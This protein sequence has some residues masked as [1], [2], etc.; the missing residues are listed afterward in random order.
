MKKEVLVLLYHNIVDTSKDLS[1]YDVGL[2]NF[3]NQL[4]FLHEY[5]FSHFIVSA[6]K[7]YKKNREILLTFDDG[8]ASWEEVVLP[9]LKNFDIKAFFFICIKHMKEGRISKN[10][11]HNLKKEG[12]NIGS[13]LMTHRFLH[14]LSK[15]EIFYELKESKKIL[16]DIIQDEIKY[17]SVPGGL[18][19]PSVI[20][21]AKMVG[22]QNIF[23]S[24]VGININPDYIFKRIPIKRKTT[25]KEFKSIIEGKGIFK[26]ILSQK[27]KNIAKV[28][29]VSYT[30]LT[31]PTKA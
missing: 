24:D 29:S 8:Y 6:Y 2:D 25:L 30:H 26:K 16:E 15:E 17:F 19:N 23:T 3:K 9:L 21:I 5:K 31:L 4:E 22:Y 18:Y 11:I 20:E 14:K 28:M 12:M 10:Q 13:H 27:S 7:D 1:L